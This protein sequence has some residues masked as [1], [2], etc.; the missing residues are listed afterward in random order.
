MVIYVLENGSATNY[1]A[2]IEVFSQV[3]RTEF[4]YSPSYKAAPAW[5]CFSVAEMHMLEKTII[6]TCSASLLLANH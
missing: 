6:K 1:L 4:A 2:I 5:F 3:T